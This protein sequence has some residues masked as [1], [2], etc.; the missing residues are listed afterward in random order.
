M[1][2]NVRLVLTEKIFVD[3]WWTFI[4]TPVINEES[5]KISAKTKI[6]NQLG[7]EKKITLKTVIYDAKGKYVFDVLSKNIILKNP[8]TEI[9]QE[10]GTGMKVN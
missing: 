7:K 2:R 1:Y 8:I 10:I 9:D 4:T 6:R 5:A 3:H